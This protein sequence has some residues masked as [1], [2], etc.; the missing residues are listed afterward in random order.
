MGFLLAVFLGGIVVFFN[1]I[2]TGIHLILSR[3]KQDA[4]RKY[5]H[6]GITID[7]DKYIEFYAST[8]KNKDRDDV[9]KLRDKYEVKT[10]KRPNSPM[11]KLRLEAI[12]GILTDLSF[13]RKD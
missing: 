6:L 8:L 3:A 12:E 5:K 4:Q 11:N 13:G 9:V 10:I 1:A 7:A 2:R